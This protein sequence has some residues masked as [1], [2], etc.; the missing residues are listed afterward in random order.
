MNKHAAIVR[1]EPHIL[2]RSTSA[3]FTREEFMHMAQAGA[4][5]DMKIELVDGEIERMNPPMSNHTVRLS[6]LSELLAPAARAAGLFA[7]GETGIDIGGD[8]VRVCDAAVVRHI[9]EENRLFSADDIILAIE[10]AETTRAR[11]M[12]PK[13]TDYASIGIENY[14]VVDG[15]RSVIHVF[16]EPVDGDYAQ[17]HTVRFGEPLTVPGTDATIIID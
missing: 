14:W 6:R 2:F 11:D 7:L 5:D 13:R 17:V 16:G 9:P 10:V 3:R 8:T 15:A 1:A 12:G 4:F